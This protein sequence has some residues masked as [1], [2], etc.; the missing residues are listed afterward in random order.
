MLTAS[1]VAAALGGEVR[2]NNVVAPG[3][4]H[5][6]ADRSLSILIDPRAP[7]GFVVHSFSDDDPLL[8]KKYAKARLGLLGETRTLLGESVREP[9]KRQSS[10]VADFI[11]RV[12]REASPITNTP[13]DAYLAGRGVSYT[14]DALRWHRACPFA[15]V[16][17]SCMVALV[18]NIGT[19]AIQGLH[20][21]AIDATGRKISSLGANG[22]LSLGK[23]SLGAIKL[24]DDAEVTTLIAIGEGIETTLSIRAVPQLSRMPIWSVLSAGGIAAFPSL[25]GIQAVWIAADNDFSGAGFKAAESAIRRL[26]ADGVEVN[27]VRPAAVGTDLNDRVAHHV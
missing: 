3:P 27:V 13:A 16:R 1:R 23:T 17:V 12:W 18:R 11:E 2:G 14:G 6:P 25:S 15:G 5:S 24:T 8:A 4:G 21:T 26:T 7:D 22:R 9:G 20:R 10:N 19:N